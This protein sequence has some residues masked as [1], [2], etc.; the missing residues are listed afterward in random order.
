MNEARKSINTILQ[1]Y[2]GLFERL[3]RMVTPEACFDLFASLSD[4]YSPTLTVSR[5]QGP[6]VEALLAEGV[7]S[8]SPVRVERSLRR[9]GTIG[10]IV[11]EE[12]APIW[13]SAHADI[14]SYLTGAWNGN[15]YP[16]TPFC[17]HRA[18]PGRRPAWAVAA[19]DGAG[20]LQRLAAGAMVTDEQN[21]VFFETER[22][23]LPLWTRVVHHLPAS[24]DRTSDEIHGFIDN[25]GG[26]AAMLLAARVLSH[27]KA[28]ALLLL[29]DEEEGPVNIGNR[30]FS[31]A[32]TRLLHRTPHDLLPEM[33]VIVD[34]QQQ[35]GQLESGH[36]TS[37]GRGATFSGAASAARGAVTPPQLLAFTREL[38]GELAGRGIALS[39]NPNYVSRSDDVSA[40]FYTQ[41]VSVIGFPGAY[42]HF[43]RTPVARCGDLVHLTKV[44]VVYVLVAQD[45]AWREAYLS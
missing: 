39:E 28:N 20:P 2:E 35:E 6:L 12:P 10:V 44:L 11:G 13:L 19:P 34:A 40:L 14:C 37:F 26:S 25:Q 31:R 9:S 29:N 22:R 36:P 41:N 8:A 38:A 32:H 24:W 21:R 5:V 30:A 27:F 45:P 23:D 1:P 18:R 42:S 33:T 4:N 3:D 15:A 7:G 43:D 17:M 16:L